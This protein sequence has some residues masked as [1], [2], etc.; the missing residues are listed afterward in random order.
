M[1]E[2]AIKLKEF[3]I[4]KHQLIKELASIT[5]DLKSL[6]SS[7]SNSPMN[8]ICTSEERAKKSCCYE[9]S[10]SHFNISCGNS[11]V[12]VNSS[13]SKKINFICISPTKFKKMRFT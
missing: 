8:Y 9:C 13:K 3:L 1:Q 7:E 2:Y 11:P 4:K 12:N 6:N 10:P 5:K